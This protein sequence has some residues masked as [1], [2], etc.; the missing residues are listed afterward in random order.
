MEVGRAPHLKWVICA[1]VIAGLH[2]IIYMLVPHC[3]YGEIKPGEV[4]D[5]GLGPGFPSSVPLHSPSNN[6]DY[7]I[8]DFIFYNYCIIVLQCN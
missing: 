2:I 5:E 6:V 4:P 3:H 1:I 8:M 7:T